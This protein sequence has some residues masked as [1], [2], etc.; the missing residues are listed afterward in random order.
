MLRIRFECQNQRA[1]IHPRAPPGQA[2]ARRVR[3]IPEADFGDR[4]NLVERVA[5]PLEQVTPLG[6]ETP[7]STSAARR[8]PSRPG[9]RETGLRATGRQSSASVR[10]DDRDHAQGRPTQAVGVLRARRDETNQKEACERVGRSAGVNRAG[11][12]RGESSVADAGGTGRKS[13]SR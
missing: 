11:G 4:R 9:D 6:E 13:P 10:E 12:S 5:A 8:R 3:E 1:E 7:S 2:R